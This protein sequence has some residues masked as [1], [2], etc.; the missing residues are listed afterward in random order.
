M[1]VL[2]SN[3]NSPDDN[4]NTLYK[5]IVDPLQGVVTEWTPLILGST[6]EGD[7]TYSYQ[8]G[9]T[10]TYGQV[11]DVW[12]DI[13][14]TG[15]TGTGNLQI[16]LPMRVFPLADY[17]PFEG[18]ISYSRLDLTANYY[19]LKI[20]ALPDEEKAAFYQVSIAA[21]DTILEM[22]IATDGNIRGHIRYLRKYDT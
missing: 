6:T 3:Y 5:D 11:V 19:C 7:G 8:Y 21:A 1:T 10:I 4:I 17:L 13:D 14:W 18:E 2:A 22:P 20:T 15:H 9:N 16:S 12:F